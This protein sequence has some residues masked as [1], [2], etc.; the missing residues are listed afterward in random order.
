MGIPPIVALEIGTSKTVALVGEV[1]EGNHILITGIGRH[2]SKG[3]RK[4]E[5]ND[6]ENAVIC[7]KSALEGAEESSQVAIRQLHLVVSGGHIDSYVNRGSV[8]V[9]DNEGEIT[10]DDVEQVMAVAKAVNL[11]PEREILHT[12]CQHFWVDDEQK[13]IRPEGM[14]GAKLSLDILVMH[15]VRN[16]LHNTIRVVKS[17]PMDVEDVAFSGLCS[18]LAVLTPEQK[19][20]GAIVIDL[21]AGTTDYLAYAG[22]VVAAAGSIGVG[23]DHVTNDIAQAF[24][25][26]IAQAE[27]LKRENGC[28]SVDSMSSAQRV[29]LP[30]E[31]GFPGRNVHLKSLN[32]VINLR[33]EETLQMVKKRITSDILM[34]A[35]AGVIL[36]GGGAHLKGVIELTEKIFS[37]PCSVGK[38]KNVSGLATATEGLEFASCVGMVQYA[39]RSMNR[40][41]TDGGIKG[42]L[43]GI[44]GR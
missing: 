25:I 23:A 40:R 9:F 21:G 4:G 7:V 10:D 14:E 24:N 15:G 43:R 30:A 1:R 16:R 37:L 13:V 3:V 42:L 39:V 44:F 28:V 26:P 2:P 5:I 19:K 8:P 17:I 18:A 20:S 35:G 29:S 31:V 11:P 22:N 33:I 27:K 12:I 38:P 34:Q 6:L 41:K 36:V 32:T